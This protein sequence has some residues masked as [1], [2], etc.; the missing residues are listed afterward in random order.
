MHAPRHLI[1]PAGPDDI[2]GILSLVREAMSRYAADSG[3]PGVLPALGD[4]EASVLSFME[5]GLLLVAE[6]RHTGALDGTIRLSVEGP[7][8]EGPLGWIGRFAVR[9][10][11]QRSGLGTRLFDAVEQEARRLGVRRIALHTALSN[12][13]LPAFYEARGMRVV[14]VAHDRGY[15][16]AR[17][18]KTLPAPGEVAATDTAGPT[19]PVPAAGPAPAAQAA[20]MAAPEQPAGGQ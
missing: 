14:S 2:P 18:E 15:P 4:T 11:L 20:G 6:D 12:P 13:R 9:P 10:S 1:R 16:R 19:G 17:F 8:D 5:T 3:I 7:G